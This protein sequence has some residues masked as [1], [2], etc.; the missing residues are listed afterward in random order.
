MAEKNPAEA[1]Q[2]AIRSSLETAQRLAKDSLD[3]GSDAA[4][5]IQE[6]VEAFVDKGRKQGEQSREAAGDA[7]ANLLET[8]KRVAGETQEAGSDAAK[9]VQGAL[10]RAI[11]TVRSRVG[12]EGDGKMPSSQAYET[13]SRDELYERAQQLDIS[14]R[15]SMNKDALI[16]ALREQ[17]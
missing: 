1:A 4:R 13:W 8:A 7:V 17:A 16:K 14:G 11:M 5:K 2:D 6:A 12:G 9:D 10:E 3:A 15:A